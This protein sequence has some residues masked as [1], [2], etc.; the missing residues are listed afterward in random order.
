ME[1]I[2]FRLEV[3]SV[4]AVIEV[5][6]REYNEEKGC[7]SL[8]IVSPVLHIVFDL[9]G[10]YKSQFAQK[11]LAEAVRRLDV[12]GLLSLAKTRLW[13]VVQQLP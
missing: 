12:K 6:G 7:T 10:K 8:E 1:K 5:N 9:P 3:P 4:T 11:R 2:E 13:P